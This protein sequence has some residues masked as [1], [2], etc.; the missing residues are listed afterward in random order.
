MGSPVTVESQTRYGQSQLRL[1]S[2]RSVAVDGA[3]P[4]N[5]RAQKPIYPRT[6]LDSVSADDDGIG[7]IYAAT[8]EH[9]LCASGLVGYCVVA[10]RAHQPWRTRL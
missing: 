4:S 7:A 2:V 10:H 6:R 3:R 5:R 8:D 1:S 9:A